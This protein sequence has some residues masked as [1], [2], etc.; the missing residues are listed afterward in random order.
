VSSRLTWLAAVLLALAP[1][2]ALACASCVSSAFGDRSYNWAF[3]GLVLLPF[4]VVG[5][6]GGLI[7]REVRLARETATREAQEEASRAPLAGAPWPPA[8]IEERT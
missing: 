7:A 1:G 8:T 2:T 5:I 3:L 4:V 6:V